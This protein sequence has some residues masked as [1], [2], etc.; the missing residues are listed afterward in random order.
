MKNAWKSA[1]EGK[2]MSV[3][4]SEGHP[5][6]DYKEH[7]RTYEGFIAATKYGV[8]SVVVLL[9]FMALTLL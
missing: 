8:I 2:Q 7:T 4:T 9:I 1:L 3:D 5:A 6:M